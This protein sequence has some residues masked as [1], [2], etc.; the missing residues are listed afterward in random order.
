MVF[1][2][3]YFSIYNLPFYQW[4]SSSP[5][6]HIFVSPLEGFLKFKQ[7][8]IVILLPKYNVLLIKAFNFCPLALLL[9]YKLLH[10]GRG[11][12]VFL[13]PKTPPWCVGP[14]APTKIPQRSTQINSPDPFL[15][16]HDLFR[17]CTRIVKWNRWNKWL[18]EKLLT[19]CSKVKACSSTIPTSKLLRIMH[20][21]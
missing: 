21:K 18:F 9:G 15:Q 6:F 13:N 17:S 8:M 4:L 19:C 5:T 3:W 2:S 20:K 12:Y 10:F 14:S 16:Y 1:T 7:R 11:C